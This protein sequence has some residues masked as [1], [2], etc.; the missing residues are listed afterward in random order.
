VPT[1]R[2]KEF[3]TGFYRFLEAEHPKVLEELASKNELTDELAK[4][5]TE[6]LDAFRETF[7]VDDRQ[8]KPATPASGT[9]APG[10]A[11]SSTAAAGTSASADAASA[12]AASADAASA[13]AASGEPAA[14]V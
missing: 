1:P 12:D 14:G 8:A 13:D 9:P 2:V 7:L 5:L 11:A 4:A 10:P 3:E 6:A